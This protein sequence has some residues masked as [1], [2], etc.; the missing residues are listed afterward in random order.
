MTVYDYGRVDHSADGW[1]HKTR[2][3]GWLLAQLG[4]AQPRLLETHGGEGGLWRACYAHIAT[5]TVVELDLARC[6]LLTRQRPGWVVHC[7]DS[8]AWLRAGGHAGAPVDLLDVDP[9]GKAWDTLAAFFTPSR[10]YA[11]RMGVAVTDSLRHAVRYQ[12]GRDIQA[13]QPWVARY[14]RHLHR[15]YLRVCYERLAALVAP[16]GYHIQAWDGAYGGS[17]KT[18]SYLAFVLERLGEG[19][20]GADAAG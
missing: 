17:I 2:Q 20:A 3:R 10:V 13:L 4:L 1:A 7:G 5:G 6:R 18:V 11:P 16:R 14:G 9:H 15:F 8:L 19:A 12:N